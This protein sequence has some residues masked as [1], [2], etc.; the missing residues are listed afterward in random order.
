MYNICIL[1]YVHQIQK[2][3]VTSIRCFCATQKRSRDDSARAPYTEIQKLLNSAKMRKLRQTHVIGY[4][5]SAASN[6]QAA[7]SA[8]KQS[9]N[10]PA[11]TLKKVI[12]N[13]TYTH[14]LYHSVRLTAV[15]QLLNIQNYVIH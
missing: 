6:H 3:R 1:I 13:L 14:E 8:A 9:K 4:P 11:S 15:R 12:L 10:F 7:P 5:N 2:S